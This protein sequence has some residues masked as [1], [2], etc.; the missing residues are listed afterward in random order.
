MIRYTFLII[1]L[2]ARENTVEELLLL[3]EIWIISTIF[4]NNWESGNHK[5]YCLKVFIVFIVV[6]TT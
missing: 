5:D 2:N 1:K 4:E 3:A 6:N